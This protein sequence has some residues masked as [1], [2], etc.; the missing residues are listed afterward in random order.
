[1]LKNKVKANA[2]SVFIML[3][4]GQYGHLDIVCDATAYA[5]I[6]STAAYLRPVQ[7]VL[8]LPTGGTQF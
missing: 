8:T 3:G 2:Q 4:G 1:M 5:V 7:P 6:L